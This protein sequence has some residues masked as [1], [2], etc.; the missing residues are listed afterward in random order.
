[1]AGRR[2]VRHGTLTLIMVCSVALTGQEGLYVIISHDSNI[3][4]GRWEILTSSAVL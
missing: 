3:S 1:M 4:T 2:R